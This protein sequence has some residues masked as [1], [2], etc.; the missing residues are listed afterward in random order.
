ML[1]LRFLARPGS[2][3]QVTHQLENGKWEQAS[4]VL[5]RSQPFEYHL[6]ADQLLANLLAHMD[7]KQTG[8]EIRQSLPFAVTPEQ[9]AGVFRRL[10]SGGFVEILE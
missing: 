2:T 9:L 7:G 8:E 5:K 3:L 4:L 6:S 10:A 1:S